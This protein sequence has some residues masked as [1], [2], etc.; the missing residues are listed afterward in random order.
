[1]T[2]LRSTPTGPLCRIVI[3]D[4]DAGFNRQV[5]LGNSTAEFRRPRNRGSLRSS[6]EMLCIR[7]E[8][9]DAFTTFSPV[10]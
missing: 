10:K 4:V 5:D 1:M 3:C 6:R 8:P 9:R 2:Y 7:R